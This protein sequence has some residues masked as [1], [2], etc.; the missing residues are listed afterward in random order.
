MKVTASAGRGYR[1]SVATR[2]GASAAYL[3][4]EADIAPFGRDSASL[5]P[6]L[7]A[8]TEKHCP[9]RNRG[10]PYLARRWAFP[11]TSLE[12]GTRVYA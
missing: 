2:F 3:L 8:G 4:N 9:C 12:V 11:L 6:L 10:A 1:F 5:R 7:S